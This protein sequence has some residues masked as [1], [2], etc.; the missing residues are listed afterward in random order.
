[1][2]IFYFFNKQDRVILYPSAFI[3]VN[4][5]E[6]VINSVGNISNINI[7]YLYIDFTFIQKLHFI[8]HG[9][10]ALAALDFFMV[11]VWTSHSFR[12]TQ[13]V[14]PFWTSVRHS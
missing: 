11:E 1:M 10:T 13:S 2:I 8:F 6:C 7:C 9:L 5:K 14:G 3:Q 4:A 12:K